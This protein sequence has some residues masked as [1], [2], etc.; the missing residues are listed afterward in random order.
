MTESFRWSHC[1]D[2]LA[3]VERLN[4]HGLHFQHIALCPRRSWMYLH[5]INFAQW[6]ERVAVGAVRHLTSYRRDHSTE[7]LF[8]LAPDRIDWEARIV[9]E[10]KG[11]GGAVEAA[12]DQTAFYALMLSIASGETWRAMTHILSNRRRREVPL[13]PPQLE[14]LWQSRRAPGATGGPPQAATSATHPPLR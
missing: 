8:G 14:R 11:T 4:L 9:Y 1:E 10:N 3:T 7:G 6:H 12:A 13:D 5:D 2:F